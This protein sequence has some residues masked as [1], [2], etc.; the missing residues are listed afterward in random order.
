[1][2]IPYYITQKNALK[3][4][5][6]INTLSH[7]EWG[8]EG[9]ILLKVYRSLVRSKLDYGSIC[10][11]N[12]DSKI[13][14][15]VDTLHNAELRFSIGSFK[16]SSIIRLL[17]LTGEPPLQFHRLKL[18][19]NYIARI[20]STPD[21]ST[22]H[23]LNQQRF[24]DIYKHNSKLRKPLGMRLQKEI[25]DINIPIDEI[26]QWENSQIPYL[27][28]PNYQVP[29]YKLNRTLEKRNTKYYL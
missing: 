21:N 13:L 15:I 27:K 7:Y 24:S 16:S 14:K 19:F 10:Y 12:T 4:L 23:V 9:T 25:M 22:I 5:N 1:L 26:Y 17:S 20:I 6:V 2:E 11:G 18:S 3:S 8:A 29:R 28:Q